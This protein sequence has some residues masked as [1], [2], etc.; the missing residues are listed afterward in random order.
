[1]TAKENTMNIYIHRVDGSV[2]EH[3]GLADHSS[4]EQHLE[5]MGY[6]VFPDITVDG[7]FSG[8]YLAIRETGEE[9]EDGEYDVADF[10]EDEDNL[11]RYADELKDE[12]RELFSS[13]FYSCWDFPQDHD[14]ESPCPWGCPWTFGSP[15]E[16][17]G[18]TIEEM[19]KN[20]WKESREEISGYLAEELKQEI[21]EF[22]AGCEANGI[23]PQHLIREY[24]NDPEADIDQDGDIHAGHWY[25]SA[26]KVAFLKWAKN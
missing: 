19:A 6:E 13:E 4:A 7:D 22:V 26:E 24:S 10:D 21:L 23:G 12:Q 17:R 8:N 20:W 9:Y 25:S 2:S 1:M 3:A 14:S 18:D 5:D 11:P 16:L 15:V